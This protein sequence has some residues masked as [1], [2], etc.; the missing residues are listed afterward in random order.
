MMAMSPVP[1]LCKAVSPSPRLRLV[2]Q[3]AELA[4]LST[5]VAGAPSVERSA[6]VQGGRGGGEG[7]G[8]GGDWGAVEEPGGAVV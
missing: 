1:D 8:Q 3:K 7:G 2:E 6:D 4:L 5:G